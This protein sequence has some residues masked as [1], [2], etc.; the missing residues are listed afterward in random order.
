M[1]LDVPARHSADAQRARADALRA[2][3]DARP[4]RQCPYTHTTLYTPKGTPRMRVWT[5][6]SEKR[7]VVVRFSCAM[8]FSCLLARPRPPTGSVL[9]TRQS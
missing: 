2:S 3:A 6:G 7:E 5:P 4:T 8:V 9:R 1:C